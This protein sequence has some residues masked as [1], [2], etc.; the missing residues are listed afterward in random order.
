MIMWGKAKKLF[1]EI[2]SLADNCLTLIDEEGLFSDSFCDGFDNIAQKLNDFH[3]EIRTGATKGVIVPDDVNFVFKIPF[4]ENEEGQEYRYDYCDLEVCHYL[5]AK[6]QCLDNFFCQTVYFDDI[7]TSCGSR[8]P[9]YIQA[10]ATSF[11]DLYDYD[12]KMPWNYPRK[13]LTKKAATYTGTDRLPLL[14]ISDFLEVY[15]ED[16]FD[17][18]GKFLD[19]SD[20]NDLHA[21]N[22]GYNEDAFPIIFDFSGFHDYTDETWS[23]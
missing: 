19:A 23:Y 13:Y 2:Q 3:I 5:R 12:D 18:L 22:V 7:K 20:I 9:V 6:N 21:A 15:G 11:S 16:N 1:Q 17:A 8:I 14:W 4:L 10:K